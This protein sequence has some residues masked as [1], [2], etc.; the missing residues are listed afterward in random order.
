MLQCSF[1]PL[2]VF[3]TVGLISVTCSENTE[4]LSLL[5]VQT[6]LMLE[7]QTSSASCIQTIYLITSAMLIADGDTEGLL[8]LTRTSRALKCKCRC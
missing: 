6:V 3:L 2:K 8:M 1:S 7:Y 4:G 5:K